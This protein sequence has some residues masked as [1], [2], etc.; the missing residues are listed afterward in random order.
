MGVTDGGE[1]KNHTK[2]VKEVVGGVTEPVGE[3][4][5]DN[6]N[7][8]ESHGTRDVDKG[9][10]D[11]SSLFL[12]VQNS[13]LHEG[14]EL[15]PTTH[16]EHVQSIDDD[17]GLT[18]IKK[19]STWTRLVRMDV[20]P[21]GML[22]EGVESILGKRHKLAVLADGEA[23]NDSNNGKKVKVGEDLT[24]NEVAGVLQNPC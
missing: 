6:G 12:G 18:N 7:R 17:V 22:K 23:E 15:A 2:T 1:E 14:T 9:N 8:A 21:V 20:G 16:E 10:R 13:C 5:A 24:M 11:L 19:P 4:G 3:N